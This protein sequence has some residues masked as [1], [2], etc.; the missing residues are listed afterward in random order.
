MPGNYY[1]YFKY[2]KSNKVKT[3]NFLKTLDQICMLFSLL[4]PLTTLP[5]IYKIEV[6]GLSLSMWVLYSVGVIPFLLYGVL[7]KARHLIILN[8]LWLI[9]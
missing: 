4:M 6:A 7:H 1:S 8:S 3:I 9:F 2:F 5:Q